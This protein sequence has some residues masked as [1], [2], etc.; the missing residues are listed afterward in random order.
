VVV[1]AAADRRRIVSVEASSPAGVVAIGAGV[2]TFGAVLTLARVARRPPVRRPIRPTSAVARWPVGP[3]L[4]R[5]GSWVGTA[6][7]AAVVAGPLGA[8]IVA[9]PVLALP[10]VRRQ[11]RAQRRRR[12]VAAAMPDA[13]ELFVICIHA[14]RSPPQAIAEL[15]RSAPVAVR[16]AFEAVELQLHRGRALADAL[17]AVPQ[18]VGPIGR[19]LATA[20][21]TA[22]RDGLPLAPVLDRLAAEARAQ[23]RRA[24]DAAAR[25]LPVRLSFPL[26]ACTLPSF[27]LLAIAP[28]V[29]GAL[30]TL[31]GRS[32]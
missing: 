15:A 1:D 7:L 13:I 20:V 3:R 14:G 23:R 27:V 22:E 24:G 21:A 30:S 8:A 11:R 2:A 26:V 10:A 6:L 12:E 31:R 25:R 19:E 18:V 4:R 5:W 9:A 16:P 17:T 29:L 32:P 28:A